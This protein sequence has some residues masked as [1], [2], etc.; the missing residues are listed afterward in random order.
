MLK[1]R[2][3]WDRLIFYMGIPVLVRRHLYIDGQSTETRLANPTIDLSHIS[4]WSIQKEMCL[5]LLWMVHC[6]IWDKCI[7]RFE[8][9]VHP[10]APGRYTFCTCLGRSIWQFLWWS[11]NYSVDDSKMRFRPNLNYDRKS[12]IK[13]VPETEK[14]DKTVILTWLR[15]AWYD[16]VS[17]PLH[18]LSQV[19]FYS[20]SGGFGWKKSNFSCCVK[21]LNTPYLPLQKHRVKKNGRAMGHLSLVISNVHKNSWRFPESI[22]IVNCA[23]SRFPSF[24]RTE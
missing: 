3:S 7:V 12:E 24:F 15:P 19:T 20:T 4:Q 1:I 13:F 17:T 8:N 11:L 5:F 2:R 10:R 22:W 9:T 16:W 23:R 21:F 14:L 18:F 6:G